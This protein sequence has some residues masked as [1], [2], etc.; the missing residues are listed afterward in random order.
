[1][2]SRRALKVVAATGTESTE[3]AL[4]SEPEIA[5]AGS[6]VEV[7]I[8]GELSRPG[9]DTCGVETTTRSKGGKVHA[10]VMEPAEVAELVDTISMNALVA[11]SGKQQRF[12]RHRQYKLFP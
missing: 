9:T 11:V 1:V 3:V 4:P 5:L 6:K 2:C 10:V 12:P 8:S 7:K